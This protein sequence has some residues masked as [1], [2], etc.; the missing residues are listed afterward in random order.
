[1]FFTLKGYTQHDY[2]VGRFRDELEGDGE[3][4]S[5]RLALVFGKRWWLNFLIPQVNN[6]CQTIFMNFQVWNTNQL[7]PAIARNIFLSI[8]KDL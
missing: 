2:N 4:Y 3:N 8:S 5:E 1:M 7:T 6:E